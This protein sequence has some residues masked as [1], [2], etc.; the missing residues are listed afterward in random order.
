MP[1]TPTASSAIGS[2]ADGSRSEISIQRFKNA[3]VAFHSSLSFS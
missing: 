2:D 1:R 3:C